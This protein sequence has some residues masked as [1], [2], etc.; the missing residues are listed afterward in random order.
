MYVK[1]LKNRAK[2]KKKK[3]LKNGQKKSEE[4]KSASESL[5]TKRPAKDQIICCKKITL[6]LIVEHQQHT[7][8]MDGRRDRLHCVKE[9]YDVKLDLVYYV[10]ALIQNSEILNERPLFLFDHLP[11][12]ILNCLHARY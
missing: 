8:K 12:T 1:S 4:S 2:K 10:T 7:T 9:L 5:T 3:P 11:E 6:A